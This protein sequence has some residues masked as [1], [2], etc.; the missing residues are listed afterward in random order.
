[1]VLDRAPAQLSHVL[2]WESV[3]Q[4]RNRAAE[5]MR[6]LPKVGDTSESV[7]DG[8]VPL[9]GGH[10]RVSIEVPRR[11]EAGDAQLEVV[12]VPAGSALGAVNKEPIDIH[13]LYNAALKLDGC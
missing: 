11:G 7:L 1:M 13:S 6:F 4:L 12:L 8:V 9:D 5:W 3:G 10:P 2:Y